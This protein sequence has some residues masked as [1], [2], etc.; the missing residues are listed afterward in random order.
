MNSLNLFSAKELKN[1]GIQ[2]AAQNAEQKHEGWGDDAYAALKT[3][4]NIHKSIPFMCETV[5]DFAHIELGLPQPASSRAWGSVF[6]RASR[7]G[8][9]KHVGYGNTNNPRAHKTP[10][11]MWEAV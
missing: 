10:A 4:I 5:R 2:L 3:Y 9:I 11:G 1:A 7:E 8:L 6:Q